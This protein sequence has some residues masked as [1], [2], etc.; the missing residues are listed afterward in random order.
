MKISPT[1]RRNFLSSIALLSAGT[2]F[3]S[4]SSFLQTKEDNI[5][6]LWKKLCKISNAEIIHVSAPQ[7]LAEFF[8][9]CKG[10]YYRTG[11][12]VLFA[13]DRL[14]AIPN[15]ISWGKEKARPDDVIINFLRKDSLQKV[16]SINFFELAAIVSSLSDLE[17]NP[18]SFIKEV[19]VKKK[20]DKNQS[21]WK[22][23]TNIHRDRDP[24]IQITIAGKQSIIN[25]SFIY[26]V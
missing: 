12:P 2:A 8:I 19:L 20:E 5:E 4:V 17:R 6:E 25:R 10:H 1:S 7:N 23:K 13:E 21:I 22:I 15:W 9:P 14:V 26:N 16:G 3:G 11:Q 18:I 24:K